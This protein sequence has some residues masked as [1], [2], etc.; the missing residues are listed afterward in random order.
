M[1]SDF[2]GRD[3]NAAREAVAQASVWPGESHFIQI[4]HPDER[5]PQLEGHRPAAADGRV[6]RGG[7]ARRRRGVVAGGGGGARFG[8]H[9]LDVGARLVEAG[10]HV[11]EAA[12]SGSTMLP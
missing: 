1:I 6:R 9:D 2:F 8:E 3:V 7:V 12:H 4:L 10:Q 11:C 5:E